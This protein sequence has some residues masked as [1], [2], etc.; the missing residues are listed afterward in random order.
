MLYFLHKYRTAPTGMK[1]DLLEQVYDIQI[2]LHGVG[3][4]ASTLRKNLM[5]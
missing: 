1:L 3:I 2:M 4:Y 5:F